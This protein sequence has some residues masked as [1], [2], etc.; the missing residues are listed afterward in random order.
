MKD[1]MELH[2]GLCRIH[3]LWRVIQKIKSQ[4]ILASAASILDHCYILLAAICVSV[5]VCVCGLLVGSIL[6]SGVWVAFCIVFIKFFCC[7][8]LVAVRTLM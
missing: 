5:H 6:S 2:Y 7:T 3:C 8:L 4:N 1:D